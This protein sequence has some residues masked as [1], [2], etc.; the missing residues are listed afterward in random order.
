LLKTT[1]RSSSRK[2]F[3]SLGERCWPTE[4]VRLDVQAGWMYLIVGGSTFSTERVAAK[5]GV[6]SSGTRESTSGTTEANPVVK[7]AQNMRHVMQ[8][9][10]GLART[11]TAR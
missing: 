6:S 10:L 5:Y 9:P 11:V 1:C 8:D 2:A 4:V 7:A 3:R